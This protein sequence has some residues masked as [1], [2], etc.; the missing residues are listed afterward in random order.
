MG[1]DCLDELGIDERII[2]KCEV[3]DWIEIPQ[4]TES[5]IQ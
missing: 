3:V 1:R 2:L 5:W 4:C